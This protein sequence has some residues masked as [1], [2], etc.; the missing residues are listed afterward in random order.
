MIPEYGHRLLESVVS[1][2]ERKVYEKLRN[3]LS[4]SFTVLHSVSW[5]SHN[6]KDFAQDGEADF[7]IAHPKLG[8]L[9]IEVKGG[10]IS[11][12][13]HTGSWFSTDRLGTKHLIKNPFSQAANAK[14]Q[15]LS[16]LR[17]HKDWSRIV[18]GHVCIGHAVWFPD[19]AD[20]APIKAPDRP[21]ELILTHEDFD[22]VESS[23]LGA[24]SYSGSQSSAHHVL[25]NYGIELIESLFAR[26]FTVLPTSAA[27]IADEEQQ[28]IQLTEIQFRSLKLLGSRR[29]VGITGGAGTGKTLLAL[30]KAHDLAKR[31]FKTLLLAYN[32]PLGDHLSNAIDKNLPITATSFHAFCTRL[33]KQHEGIYLDRARKDFPNS[34]YWN[35]VLPAA[36][37]YLLE[38]VKIQFDAILVDEAQDFAEE[39]WFPLEL[40][41]SDSE[42]SPLYL[43][44]DSNQ[45]LYRKTSAFPINPEEEF[46]LTEN[47]RN[48]AAIHEVMS[49]LFSGGELNPSSIPGVAVN[50]QFASNTKE[51]SKAIRTLVDRYLS[52][53]G[54]KSADIVV[55]IA[56]RSRLKEYTDALSKENLPRGFRFLDTPT[57]LPNKIRVLSAAK[58]KGLEAPIVIVCGLD[59][60]DPIIRDHRMNLYVALSRPKNVLHIVGSEKAINALKSLST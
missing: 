53:E 25:G 19:I 17:S 24:F 5:I 30:E 12:D 58:F 50:W 1:K 13:A 54:L 52:G 29:R 51:Q 23:I 37:C 21:Q 4:D 46:E 45:Q 32:R 57:I 31:G 40:M 11:F 41:L 43:F 39:F 34:D 7:L 2:A 16:A 20:S 26:D 8:I 49:P 42:R 9:I 55:L 14:H 15:V 60:L 56:D 22:F 36:I 10:G 33:L 18:L 47:C 35:V 38:Y 6:S 3:G 28:R 48:T 44:Y 27:R 59:S